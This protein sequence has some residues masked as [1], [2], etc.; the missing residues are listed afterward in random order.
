MIIPMTVDFSKAKAPNPFLS[1]S[2][3]TTYLIRQMT[4]P[5]LLILFHKVLKI[6]TCFLKKLQKKAGKIF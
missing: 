1:L 4:R 3:R 6:P 2:E 5:Y